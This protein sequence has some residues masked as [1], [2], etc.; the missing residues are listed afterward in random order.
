M[1]IVLRPNVEHI[2]DSIEQL[3]NL[4]ATDGLYD[5]GHGSTYVVGYSLEMASNTLLIN[6]VKPIK[7]FHAIAIEDGVSYE[8][9][10]AVSNL[11]AIQLVSCIFF[12]HQ[13]STSHRPSVSQKYFLP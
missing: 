2:R 8:F 3:R 13:I 7:Y 10:E 1:E 12:I 9:V 11:L 5:E 6:L 4:F